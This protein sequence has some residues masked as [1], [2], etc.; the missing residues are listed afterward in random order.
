MCRKVYNY[1]SVA[2]VRERGLKLHPVR[3]RLAAYRVAPVR[4]RGLKLLIGP[5]LANRQIV[6]PV[7]ERGLKY[8]FSYNSKNL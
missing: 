3:Y 4:E 6:A 7:R 8:D 2:P 1:L 5:L